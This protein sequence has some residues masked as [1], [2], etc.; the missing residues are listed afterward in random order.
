M[1]VGVTLKLT[2]AFGAHQCGEESVRLLVI[3]AIL[4]LVVLGTPNRVAVTVLDGGVIGGE[5]ALVVLDLGLL[6]MS[7]LG[8]MGS[9]LKHLRHR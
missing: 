4:A 3:L 8:C 7:V 9:A 6:T 5:G 2:E 1:S